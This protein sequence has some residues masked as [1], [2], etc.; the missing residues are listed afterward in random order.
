[1]GKYEGRLPAVATSI[2]SCLRDPELPLDVGDVGGL[3][4]LLRDECPGCFEGRELVSVVGDVVAVEH[5]VGFV[6][7]HAHRDRLRNASAD[8][9][10]GCRSSEV[11]AVLGTEQRQHAGP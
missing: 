11:I 9:V 6:S 8:H 4:R 1:M 5:H 3:G 10:A 7:G 2:Q